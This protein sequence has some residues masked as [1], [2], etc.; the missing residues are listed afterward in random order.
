M[1]L[2]EAIE[3]IEDMK[4]TSHIIVLIVFLLLLANVILQVA[5]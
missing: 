4:Y 2:I 5:Q 3:H 1:K